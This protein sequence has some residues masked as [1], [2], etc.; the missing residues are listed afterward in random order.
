V[1]RT[2]IVLLIAFIG[3]LYIYNYAMVWGIGHAMAL[4]IPA[5]WRSSFPTRLSGT[6]TWM[7][8]AH[9]LAVVAISVP[10]ALVIA[11]FGGRLAPV[12]AL[13][14]TL[15]LFALFSLGPLIEY[16]G[17]LPTRTK[18]VTG[19]D[20]IKLVLVLPLMVWLIRKLPSNNRWR[21]P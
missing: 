7:I 12:V 21:G 13:A 20:Q 16:F 18:V 4:P 1:T 5:G 17:T 2:R 11:R 15:I 8:L 10:F 14:M 19:F 3:L 9:T 6:L